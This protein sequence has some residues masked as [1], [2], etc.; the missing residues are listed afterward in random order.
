MDARDIL[1]SGDLLGAIEQLKQEVRR[2]P[3]DARLRTFLFQ[4]FCVT[5]DWERALTQLG[6]AAELDAAA[7]PMAQ[8]YR[9]AIRCEILRGRI[10][11]G[12]RSPTIFGQPENW[13]SLLV[14][15]NRVLASGKP[16]E[17]LALRDA[18]FDEAPAVP[19]TVNGRAVDWVADADPRLGPMLEALVDGKYYWVPLHR[20][21]KLDVE[22]PADLRDLVWLPAHF[23][24][25]NGGDAVGFIPTRYPGSAEAGTDLALARRTEWRQTGEWFLGLGQRMF[26]DAGDEDTAILDLRALEVAVAA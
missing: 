22:P 3:R 13:M 26:A 5:A 12:K 9:A 14:E 17:A 2:A 25:A 8:A 6:V 19:A 21:R 20:L 23:V 7:I 10:F 16:D 18:A 15:A 11:E 24:W 1:R 4:V